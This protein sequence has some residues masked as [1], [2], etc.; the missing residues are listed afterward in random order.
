MSPFSAPLLEQLIILKDSSLVIRLPVKCGLLQI[1]GELESF[2]SVLKSVLIENESA[3]FILILEIHN[4]DLD[5]CGSLV[6]Y[7]VR[8]WVKPARLAGLQIHFLRFAV[9]GYKSRPAVYEI[10]DQVLHWMRMHR[11]PIARIE[12]AFKHAHAIIFKEQF[13]MLRSG[14]KHVL[15]LCGNCLFPDIYLLVNINIAFSFELNIDILAMP[16]RCGLRH[17]T[18]TFVAI[19]IKDN[20]YPT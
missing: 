4:N 17:R 1:F 14:L 2:T 12:P 16:Y 9:G 6:D 10:D 11:V 3:K 19:L 7:C 13:I 15:Y 18:G 8:C 5:H 20:C